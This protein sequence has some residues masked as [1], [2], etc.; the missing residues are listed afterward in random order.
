MSEPSKDL[1]PPED[2]EPSDDKTD[3]TNVTALTMWLYGAT[4]ADV[5]RTLKYTSPQ[6]AKKAIEQT[7]IATSDGVR[8]NLELA[9]ERQ[10]RR[11]EKLFQ[12]VAT[13]ATNPKDREHLAYNSQALGILRDQSRLLGLDAPNRHIVTTAS[14]EQIEAF[15]QQIAELKAAQE[16]EEA[17]IEMVEGDGV[18]K[19]A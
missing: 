9:K 7:I 15:V 4:H 12:S 10:Y 13:R 8:D 16:P 2:E 1:L 14:E 18:W 17:D 5:A 6:A 19:E 11:L 3:S